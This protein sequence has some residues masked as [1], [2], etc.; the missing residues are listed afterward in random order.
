MPVAINLLK[1]LLS[2]GSLHALR[3]V[4]FLVKEV[5]RR[6]WGRAYGISILVSRPTD[7]LHLTA[8]VCN[9]PAS[10]RVQS[11]FVGREKIT[12]AEA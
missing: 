9:A 4:P 10:F 2:I 8:S 12:R 7:N 5:P 6:V 11:L 1:V 3:K